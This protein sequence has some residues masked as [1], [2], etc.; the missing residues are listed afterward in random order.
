[1]VVSL[2]ETLNTPPAPS[3]SLQS[4]PSG[5]KSQHSGVRFHYE[6][7]IYFETFLRR[8]D[9]GSVVCDLNFLLHHVPLCFHAAV[10]CV[11]SHSIQSHCLTLLSTS[12]SRLIVQFRILALYFQCDC[13][14]C[15]SCWAGKTPEMFCIRWRLNRS[16]HTYSRVCG[17]HLLSPACLCSQHD[18]FDDWMRAFGALGSGFGE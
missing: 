4:A 13:Q 3:H 14:Y 2:L 7:W 1:M 12:S 10:V 16:L 9:P 6:Q 5:L 15:A 11:S 18:H 17:A 8:H